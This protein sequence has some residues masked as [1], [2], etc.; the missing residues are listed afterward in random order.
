MKIFKI[1]SLIVALGLFFSACED[2][3]ENLVG[4]RGVAVIPTITS[5]TPGAP[6]FTDLTA[7]SFITFTASLAE[8]DVVDAAEIQVV[9]EGKVGV[10][11]VIES[12]P[13]D[14]KITAPEILSSLEITEADVELGTSFMIYV[15]TTLDGLTSRSKATVEIKMACEFDPEVTFGS[16]AAVSTDWGVDSNVKFL[17]DENDPYTLYI[18][19]LAEADACVSNGN[20]VTVHIDPVSFQL[21]G[22]TE[23]TI[24]AANCGGWGAKYVAYTN[25]SYTVSSG[26][27]NSCDGTYNIAFKL[28]YL[29][30]GGTEYTSWGD[31]SFTFTR[32]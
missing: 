29:P 32:N 12:F 26:F 19:G 23:R 16:Y 30:E 2:T 3:N 8:G 28:E 22:D 24:V 31:N 27:F 15:K 9:Y 11:K 6:L 1:V 13:I 20:T 4:S 10:V 25:Y 14:T 7:E 5:L 17:V 21:T 18:S